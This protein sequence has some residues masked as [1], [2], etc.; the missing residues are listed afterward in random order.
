VLGVDRATAA[1]ELEKA[2]LTAEDGDPRYS[3]TVAAGLVLATDPEPGGRVLDSGSV[4]LVLSLGPERYEVPA[5]AGMTEDQAQDALEQGNLS[6]GESREKYSDTVP[7]GQVIRST[8]KPTTVLKPDAPVDLVLSKGRRPIQLRDWT[9]EDADRA[10]AALEKRKLVVE[11]TGEEY[12]DTVPEGDVISQDPT[13]GPLYRGDTVR[14]VVSRGPEL[15][16]VPRVIAMGVDAAT[17][18]LE[19]LGFQVDVE[20]SDNYIGVGFVFSSDPSAGS[21]APKGSTITLYLI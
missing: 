7:A 20:N 4:T 17:E 9:G 8:P 11:V 3:E 21:M 18:K 19:A 12:S 15:V 1:A 13:T 6:F 10:T 14:L 16:E 5:L 2:G